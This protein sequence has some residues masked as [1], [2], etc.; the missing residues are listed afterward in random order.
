[1]NASQRIMSL[2]I[3]CKEINKETNLKYNTVCCL[4]WTVI[5]NVY[6]DILFKK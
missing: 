4:W 3:T 5:M 1:M 6:Q 2:K